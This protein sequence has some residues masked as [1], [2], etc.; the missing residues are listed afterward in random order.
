MTDAISD[1]IFAAIVGDAAGYT[2]NGMKKNHIKAVFREIK[3]YTDPA[4]GLKHNMQR[5]RKPGLYSSISQNIIITAACVDKRSLNPD[6]FIQAF[7]N[8]PEIAETD[9]SIFR[10][11]GDTEKN[12]ISLVRGDE[13][14]QQR[15]DHPCA[16]LLPASIPLLLIKDREDRSLNVIKYISLFTLNSLTQ[17][18]SLILLQLIDDLLNGSR[19]ILH[20]AHLSAKKV[21]DDIESLQ[22]NIFSLGYNP[23]Y[24]MSAADALV[25]LFEELNS[26]GDP[27]AY[28]GI[29]C[30][31][32]SK[33]SGKDISRGSINLP[34]TILPMA[35]VLSDLFHEDEN[36]FETAVMEGGAASSLASLALALA[37]ASGD[38]KIPEVL[39][40]DL[41]NRKRISALISQIGNDRL[42][43]SILE[44]FF[45]SESGLTVKEIEEYNARNRHIPQKN[46]MKKKKSRKDI[47]SEL[48]KHVVESW[49]KVD[50]AK[51]KKE[52]KRDN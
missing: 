52:R 22:S 13:I 6:K 1:I 50:K 29:I 28:E 7:K 38:S 16:R 44:D 24:I 51:W 26:S 2:L 41:A 35:V 48:S 9:Y 27:E 4:P 49:T 25:M 32:A 30:R 20:S 14:P 23:D 21:K 15:F 42:R 11:P 17:V 47:E 19:G 46:D 37:A 10:E 39:I 12:F 33:N 40:R 43:E 18:C 34:D 31:H 45:S 36:L 5:W 8:A 3:G